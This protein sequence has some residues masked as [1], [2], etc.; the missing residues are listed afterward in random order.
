MFEFCWIAIVSEVG[1]CLAVKTQ[2]TLDGASSC[3]CQQGISSSLITYCPLCII[4]MQVAVVWVH[5]KC[6][7]GD[8][9]CKC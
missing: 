1:F 9:G 7:V 8:A 2:M 6:Q 3:P 4:N 5:L